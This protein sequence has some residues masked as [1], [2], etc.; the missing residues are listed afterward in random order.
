MP[1]LTTYDSITQLESGHYRVAFEHR[2]QWNCDL[3]VAEDGVAVFW[4]DPK[5]NT[6]RDRE[7]PLAPAGDHVVA[8]TKPEWGRMTRLV[9]RPARA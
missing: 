3:I 9:P 4:I 5:D 2:T 6:K 1:D 7:F 8:T